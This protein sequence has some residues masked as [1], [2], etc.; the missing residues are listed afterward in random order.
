MD[1]NEAAIECD[2]ASPFDRERTISPV[3]E[4][5]EG[6]HAGVGGRVHKGLPL[7]VA[8]DV[9][10]PA[11]A[12]VERIMRFAFE[13]AT[14]GP[15]APAGLRRGLASQAKAGGP[16]RARTCNQTVMSAVPYWKN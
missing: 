3:R 6:K 15:P 12:G 9:S 14:V 2:R 4:N 5:P 8:T 7:E 16:G 10:I 13:L 1:N 11:R